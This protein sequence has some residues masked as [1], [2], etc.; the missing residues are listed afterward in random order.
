MRE[1]VG[2][3]CNASGRAYSGNLERARGATAGGR[4]QPPVTVVRALARRGASVLMLR[5]AVGDSL[6]GCWELPGGK[7]DELADR[8]EVPLEALARELEEECGL[9]F[10]GTPQLIAS[11]PRVSPK[12]KLV[13][14]LTFV[15]EIADGR[16]QLSH[17]HDQVCWHRLHEPAP[18][19][20]TEA[21]ADGLA[22]LRSCAVSS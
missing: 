17:E 15:G 4:A 18:G 7:V 20:L 11:A 1:R 3:S 2:I 6:G 19:Q 13:R 16:E 21:A 14:E 10:R 22:A 9:K 12:G 8:W 5:R